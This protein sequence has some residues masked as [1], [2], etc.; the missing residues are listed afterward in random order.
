MRIRQHHRLALEYQCLAPL[1]IP[2]LLGDT[3][4]LD[5]IIQA[6]V[7]GER[8]C[9]REGR[10]SGVLE[11]LASPPELGDVSALNGAVR[12]LAREQ[13]NFN[14]WYRHSTAVTALHPPPTLNNVERLDSLCRALFRAEEN[15]RTQRAT[16]DCLVRLSEPPVTEQTDPLEKMVDDLE[17]VQRI[18]GT[19][20]RQ[21]LLLDNLT[22][23]PKLTDLKQLADAVSL[24]KICLDAVADQ[25]RAIE[26]ASLEMQNLEEKL[27][28]AYREPPRPFLSEPAGSSPRRYV[29]M[30]LAGFAGLAAV[31]L[32]VVFG[33]GWFRRPSTGSSDRGHTSV[34]P[35]PTVVAKADESGKAENPL[36]SQQ[37]AQENPSKETP[38]QEPKKETPKEEPKKEE[39]KKE[40]PKED[41]KKEEPKVVP[42]KEEPKKEAPKEDPKKEEFNEA[43]RL[44]LKQVR[45]LLDDAE[46]ASQRGKYLDAVLGF[47]QAAILYP[48]ELGE[49]RNPEDVRVKFNEALQHYQ[50]EVEQALRRAAEKKPGDK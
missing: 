21:R 22:P 14:R 16:A 26:D 9:Q 49:V 44:R 25:Q 24:L 38:K 33:T 17:S 19:L 31:I 39:P 45:Q 42:K 40:V 48:Q 7:E 5:R 3:A 8:R 6:L 11:S 50:A 30:A 36:G 10:R 29:P 34:D 15:H 32:L 23:P 46:M 41:P 12:S 13:L 47:G 37:T 1:E 20:S 18:N 4:S 2:P 28:V 43:K 35:T 27:R